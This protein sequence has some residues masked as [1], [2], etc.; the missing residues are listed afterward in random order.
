MT[1]K[2]FY[3]FH[4]DND[5]WRAGQVRNIGVVD[6][7]E[8]VK[9]K[10]WE[11]VKSKSEKDI[12]EWIN[13]NLKDKSCLVVLI[14]EE[15]SERK[16]VSYEIETAWNLGKAVCGIYIH[17]LKNRDG[18]ISKEGNNPFNNFTVG[19]KKLSSIAPVFKSPY[20]DSKDVYA[21]IE[22]NIENLIEKAISIRN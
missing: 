18:N 17:K 22:K 6:G 2:V 1:R 10:R 15:T 11:D 14:G 9:G 13:N 4:F 21:D 3:S 19:D 12:K 5:A 7:S 20:T 16:W 8:P